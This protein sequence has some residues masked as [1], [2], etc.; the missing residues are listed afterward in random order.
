MG[1]LLLEKIDYRIEETSFGT[2]KRYLN[3]AGHAYHEFTS[4]ACLLGVPLLHYTAGRSPE[5]GRR[6]VAR[7]VIAVGRM[8]VGLFSIGQACV[9]V[10]SIGQ[11]SL[12][13]LLGLGQL[14]TGLFAVGQLGLGV[15]P[16]VGRLG[17][18]VCGN[19][20][21]GVRRLRAGSI[22]TGDARA[23]CQGSRRSGAGVLQIVDGPEA[24]F[25]LLPQTARACT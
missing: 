10:I 16:G 19:R 24:E 23:G 1:N 2:W 4:H 15:I 13:M 7:G 3:E 14:C 8:A 18:R 21:G 22:W 17:E 20:S 6:K 5:T 9:G 12:G 11:L 25:V